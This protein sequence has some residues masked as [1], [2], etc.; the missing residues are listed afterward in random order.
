MLIYSAGKNLEQLNIEQWKEY[1]EE[2]FDVH[3]WSLNLNKKPII[4]STKNKSK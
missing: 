1:I 4:S 2:W 3:K